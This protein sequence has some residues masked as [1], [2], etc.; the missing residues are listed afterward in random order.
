MM[1]IY[2][3]KNNLSFDKLYDGTEINY[4]QIYPKEEEKNNKMKNIA[5]F[6]SEMR[7][8]L[9]KEKNI[10]EWI[11]L[12]FG[13]N[14][15]FYSL[16]GKNYKYYPNYSEIKFKNDKKLFNDEIKMKSIDFGLL[17][18]QL[19]N[20]NFPIRKMKNEQKEKELDSF[21]C[22]LLNYEHIKEIRSPIESFICR[23]SI[24]INDNYIKIIDEKE[25]INILENYGKIQNYTEKLEIC[26]FNNY[27]INNIFGSLNLRN[28]EFPDLGLINYYF[29]GNIFGEI[30]I[31]SLIESKDENNQKNKENN[32]PEE[33]YFIEE[34][35]GDSKKTIYNLINKLNKAPIL[36]DNYTFGIK[37]IKKINDHSKEIKYIDFNPRL[38]I[39]LSYSLDNFINVY[40]F[41]KLKLINIIDTDLFKESDDKKFF[42]EVILLSYP[43]PS[44]LCHN[45]ENIY[46]LSINGERIKY[47]KLQNNEKILIFIDKNL[48]LFPDRIDIVS[49]DGKPLSIFNEI[50][51]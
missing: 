30:S 4:V 19:F 48:G 6:I 33:N 47:Q 23:G 35:E 25:E 20:K 3:N 28:T 29:I 44:I 46:L 50:N 22:L 15:K 26:K 18:Y 5:K 24:Y 21:N 42:D 9:E 11:D 31:F 14:Q 51:E 41:P 13:I 36:I 45:K 8:S 32:L 1:E 12:I 10:N 37:L 27:I 49:K 7:K 38:N 43:F 17:P 40:I 34:C 16:N 39:F 2:Y